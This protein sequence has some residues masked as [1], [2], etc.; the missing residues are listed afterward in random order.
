MSELI[1][2]I[3]VADYL[4]GRAGAL[5]ATARQVQDA[6]TTVGFFVLTGHD[7]PQ[8]LIQGTFAE[9]RRFHQLPMAKKLAL[10]LNQHNNGYMMM[11][12]YAVRTSDINNNDKGD[13][14]EA[15]FVKRERT[16]DDLLLLSGRRFVGPNLW[17]AESDLPG[18]RDGVLDYVD[19]MDR[20]A[21]H[22]LPVVAVALDLAPDWFDE[23]FTDS[24]FSFRLSHYPPVAA[25]ANQF[26]IA[27]HTDSNFMTFLA[28]TEVPGLQVR[29][30]PNGPKAGDWLDVPYLPN[31]FAVN[32]GDMLRRWSN[33]R[34]LSTPH[35]ALP[36][37]GGERY[38]IPFFLGPRFDQVI[39]CLPTCASRDNPPRWPP[40][41]YAEWQ[42]Y[43]YDA[44]Y[45]PKLQRNIA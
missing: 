12:R 26:G 32:S 1:P 6:L 17:P 22:F 40:I 3:D 7:I 15:F 9:A 42:E 38:A 43:W 35:R 21:R 25:E 41:T 45:D 29:L 10:R 4:A 14:N 27:P 19:T 23:A 34:F 31:S 8:P 30:P 24:Q 11:G 28:Q 39:E 20:F 13:L 44:N 37:V 5:A 33:G 2:V 18:F 16:P 36:P